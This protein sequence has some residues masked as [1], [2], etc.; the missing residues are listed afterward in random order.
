[1]GSLD[2]PSGTG[3]V[4]RWAWWPGSLLGSLH[5]KRQTFHTTLLEKTPKPPKP[6]QEDPRGGVWV[7]AAGAQMET[8]TKTSASTTLLVQRARDPGERAKEEKE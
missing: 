7:G 6:R 2:C 3:W 8:V 1:M 4:C 5:P